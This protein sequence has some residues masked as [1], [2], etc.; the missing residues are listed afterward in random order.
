MEIAENSLKK[1]MLGIWI[2]AIPVIFFGVF[3]VGNPLAY[4]VGE[5]VGCLTGSILLF[6]MYRCIDLELD[7]PEKKAANHS[8]SMALVRTGIVVVVM[9]GSLFLPAYINPY[10]V[11]VG[12]LGMKVSA[13]LAPVWDKLKK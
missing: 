12:M 2:L 7:L 3:F 6:H 8:R 4:V 11:L 10:M 5:L 9:G 1:V 13:L